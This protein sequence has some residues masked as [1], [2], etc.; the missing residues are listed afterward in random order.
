M[1]D[2]LTSAIS[3]KGLKQS[4][5]KHSISGAKIDHRF[6]QAI[7]FSMEQFSNIISFVGGNDAPSGTD[8][9][10]FEEL[11]DQ[12]IQNIKQI[13]STCQIYLCNAAPRGDTDTTYVNTCMV[14]DILC[15]E[16][17]ITL[18]DINKAFY[19]KQGI[20]VER[21]Y[22]N[23]LIHLSAPGVKRLLKEVDKQINIVENVE[24]GVFKSHYQ[25]KSYSHRVNPARK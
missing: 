4:V 9:E 22:R 10:Y 7:V 21:H 14:I 24:N 23:V 19:D 1:G 18:L 17:D 3:P 12:V 15:Q 2:S 20:V 25:K 13:N 8:I 11:Y 5:F 6:H 16:H